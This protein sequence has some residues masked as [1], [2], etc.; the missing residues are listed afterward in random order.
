MRKRVLGE[1]SPMRDINLHTYTHPTPHTPTH[2][3]KPTY[4]KHEWPLAEMPA[5][6]KRWEPGMGVQLVAAGVC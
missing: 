2:T 1:T 6:C 3:L 5:K 4:A